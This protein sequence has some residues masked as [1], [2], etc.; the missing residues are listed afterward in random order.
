M[1][2]VSKS[3][4]E[5]VHEP[6]IFYVNILNIKDREQQEEIYFKIRDMLEEYD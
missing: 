4:A 2:K 5:F 3:E 1:V 6:T